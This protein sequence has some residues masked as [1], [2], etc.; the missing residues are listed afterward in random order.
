[1][2]K[3]ESFKLYIYKKIEKFKKIQ[4]GTRNQF[5]KLSMLQFTKETPT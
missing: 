3:N 2:S 5:T 1:M 4:V